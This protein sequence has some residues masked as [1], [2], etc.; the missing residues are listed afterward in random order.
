MASKLATAIVKRQRDLPILLQV[1]LD[2]PN[3]KCSSINPVRTL[4]YV[5]EEKPWAEEVDNGVRR[6]ALPTSAFREGK[7]I[8]TVAHGIG[9][10]VGNQGTC[11]DTIRRLPLH[12]ARYR[13]NHASGLLWSNSHL[14]FVG[15]DFEELLQFGYKRPKMG[16]FRFRHL[17]LEAQGEKRWRRQDGDGYFLVD[18]ISF[19]A[20]RDDG[21]F[22]VATDEHFLLV[23][24]PT[25]RYEGLPSLPKRFFSAFPGLLGVAQNKLFAYVGH[26]ILCYDPESRTWEAVEGGRS[27]YAVW[28]TSG[29][30]LYKD[31][32][33]FVYSS[34]HPIKDE[35]V[36]GI[37][38]FD[39]ERREWLPSRVEGLDD[40]YVITVYNCGEH[41]RWQPFLFKIGTDEDNNPKLA[42]VWQPP[43]RWASFGPWV[44]WSKFTIHPII[45]TNPSGSG[46]PL[47]FRAQLESNGEHQLSNKSTAL[48]NCYASEIPERGAET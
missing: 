36:P 9:V 33:I 21:W 44:R 5:I 6:M 1:A 8:S 41:K 47:C 16:V 39:I 27:I 19:T 38:V 24:P 42:L 28:S 35:D 29:V 37:Y 23:H 46:Q 3:Y 12:G 32:Y 17:D 15:G 14:Y 11:C 25:G 2:R 48:L 18:Q 10:G 43:V 30:A 4:W 34:C 13:F 26:D 7:G 20:A 22:Y 45:T 31:R 40:E